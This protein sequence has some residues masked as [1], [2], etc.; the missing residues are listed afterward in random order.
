[1]TTRPTRTDP[2]FWDC[3]CPSDGIHPKSQ[4]RCPQCDETAEEWG[5]APLGEVERLRAERPEFVAIG[6]LRHLA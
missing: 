1:M 2:A 4:D 3:E 5:D 6:R